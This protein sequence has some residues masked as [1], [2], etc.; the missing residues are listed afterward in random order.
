MILRN[1]RSLE[2]VSTASTP[3][4][5]TPRPYHPPLNAIICIQCRE[6]AGS[7]NAIAVESNVHTGDSAVFVDKLGEGGGYQASPRGGQIKL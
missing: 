2:Q 7:T 3:S 5:A 6:E 4:E 1:I